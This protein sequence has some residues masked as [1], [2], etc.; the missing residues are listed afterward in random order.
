MIF[1]IVDKLVFAGFAFIINVILAKY[2][3][4][5]EYGFYVYI[6]AILYIVIQVSGLGIKNIYIKE[7]IKSK[8]I[9]KLKSNVL[10][11]KSAIWLLFSTIFFVLYL[12]EK[13]NDFLYLSIYSLFGII[14]SIDQAEWE[15]E[16]EGRFDYILYVRMG[17]LASFF[18]VKIFLLIY[19]NDVRY[20]IF[21][22]VIEIPVCYI[23]QYYIGVYKLKNRYSIRIDFDKENA[24]SIVKQAWPI[25]VGL[26]LASIYNRVDQIM[27][28]N[29]SGNEE[30]ALYGLSVKL[31]EPFNIFATGMVSYLY[32]KIT[33]LKESGQLYSWE[34]SKWFYVIFIFGIS[35]SLMLC[36]VGYN[37]FYFFD[38]SYSNAINVFR[39]LAINIPFMFIGVYL[40][41]HLIMHGL[42]KIL[43][44]RTLF[45]VAINITLNFY[46]IPLYG[47][48]GAAISTLFTVIFINVIYYFASPSTRG[49]TVG[50]YFDFFKR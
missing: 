33:K 2:L 50:L 16:I 12:C 24:C 46:L 14:Y 40:S 42:Q 30:L 22:Y 43:L 44:I 27:L 38:D 35:L 49:I 15:N 6:Q 26:V 9:G 20:L 13:N 10:V 31:T 3:S 4:P 47:A 25:L 8:D 19:I 48:F 28:S 17:V 36:L 1:S 34:S 32:P 7:Y 5:S 41:S 29:I 45:G 39:A 23:I 11:L 18:L 21:I 37:I